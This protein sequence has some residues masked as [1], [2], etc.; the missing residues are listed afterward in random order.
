MDKSELDRKYELM[1]IVDAKLTS[2][3]KND[4][5]KEATDTIVKDG[6]RVLNNQVWM[7]KHKLTFPIKK[8]HEGTYYLV[9]FESEG[10]NIAKISSD[11][12]LK[13]K[14]LRFSVLNTKN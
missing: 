8:C 7:E 10:K 9:N 1:F 5:C 14:I 13:E 4:L 12:K 3:Q 6:G 11:L 2:D